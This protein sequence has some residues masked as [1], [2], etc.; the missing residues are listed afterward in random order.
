MPIRLNP[1]SPVKELASSSLPVG[2]FSAIMELLT[3]NVP[4]LKMP[5]LSDCAELPEIVLDVTV[6]VPVPEMPPP[7]HPAAFPA[8]VLLVNVTAPEDQM[9]PPRFL[10][11]F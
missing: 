2:S 7:F 1:L 8:I 9:P 10:A 4:E 11:A 6:T 5:P 3:V